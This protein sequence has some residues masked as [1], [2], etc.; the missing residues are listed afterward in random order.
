MV[1]IL[2]RFPPNLK[3]MMGGLAVAWQVKVTLSP[4][5]TERGSMDRV[6]VGGSAQ[7]NKHNQCLTQDKLNDG[8]N[9]WSVSAVAISIKID[10][11]TNKSHNV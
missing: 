10:S 6:T 9:A 1:E 3:P 8:L 7:E 5:S 11:H 4:S 2:V